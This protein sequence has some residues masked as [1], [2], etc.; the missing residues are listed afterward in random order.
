MKKNNEDP[1]DAVTKAI[2]NVF[3]EDYCTD[4]SMIIS[5]VQ[6]QDGKLPKK[7]VQIWNELHNGKAT[8]FGDRELDVSISQLSYQIAGQYRHNVGLD[9]EREFLFVSWCRYAATFAHYK[10]TFDLFLYAIDHEMDEDIIAFW[11]R[12]TIDLIAEELS[13]CFDKIKQNNLVQQAHLVIRRVSY[14]NPKLGLSHVFTLMQSRAQTDN[15]DSKHVLSSITDD[16]IEK[17][18]G[19]RVLESIEP[20]GDRNVRAVCEKY[21]ELVKIPV[22][23]VRIGDLNSVKKTLDKE[24]PW[25]HK[26][27]QKLISS[28]QL[29]LL[30]N[31]DFFIPP[32]LILG[33]AGIG[34]TS[35][36][37]RFSQL[38]KV[39]FRAISLAGKSDNRDLVGTS[40]G[41]GTGQPSMIISLINQHKVG[42]PIVLAD[43]VDKCGGSDHNGR[44]LDTLL[45]LFEPTSAR[46]FFDEYLCGRCDFSRVS[47]ICTA[48][49]VKQIPTTLLSRLDVVTVDKPE[50][51]HYP[52]IVNR[53]ITSF[54]AENGIHS[55][56]KPVLEE[57]DWKWLQGYYTSPRITK[58]AV[59]KWLAYRLLSASNDM[60]H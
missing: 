46:H 24:F 16:L 53:S 26:L 51:E 59:Y 37:L 15:P 11:S 41:W 48:N 22:T 49:S 33:D 5:K 31:G 55:A 56:H 4:L 10:A 14:M 1:H 21:E 57:A 18:G 32:L 54:F 27:T 9:V 50:F 6:D 7:V 45:T 2:N 34:K 28:L 17:I 30:G 58:K 19:I 35:F 20:S 8:I 44:A 29:R 23:L 25:F 12:K 39:P 3:K 36:S 43:E 38:I 13:Y 42:N 52:A 47:W 40:R 60:V